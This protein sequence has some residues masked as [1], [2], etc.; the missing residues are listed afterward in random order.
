MDNNMINIAYDC[1]SQNINY[2]LGLTYL[3]MKQD[4]RAPYREKKK[5]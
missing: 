4:F 2:M 3:F 1:V 5:S